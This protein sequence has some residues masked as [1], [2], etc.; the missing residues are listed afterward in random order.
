[1][2]AQ[3]LAAREPIRLPAC[4]FVLSLS[5]HGSNFALSS[6]ELRAVIR[7]H[8]RRNEFVRGNNPI[9]STIFRAFLQHR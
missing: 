6:T 4:V 2:V 7:G 5:A 9:T 1:M 8:K 3:S